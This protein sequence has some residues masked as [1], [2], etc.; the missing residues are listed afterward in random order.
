MSEAKVKCNVKYRPEV[1]SK[2][3]DIAQKKGISRNQ[4]FEEAA[5]I[6]IMATEKAS[7]QQNTIKLKAKRVNWVNKYK[8]NL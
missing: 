5:M 2:M 1:I 6:Y 7:H 8:D 4:A 3:E